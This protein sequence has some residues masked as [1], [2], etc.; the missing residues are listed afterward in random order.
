MLSASR[1]DLHRMGP[2][3]PGFQIYPTK[4][5]FPTSGVEGVQ[6]Q[7]P[8][9]RLRL[10]SP[11]LRSRRGSRF[12]EKN[13]SLDVGFQFSS[14]SSYCN[15]SF[16]GLC[17]PRDPILSRAPF[18]AMASS[19]SLYISQTPL[20]PSPTSPFIAG[21]SSGCF[22]LLQWRGYLQLFGA[23]PRS[24]PRSGITGA[25]ISLSR[26]THTGL[27]GTTGESFHWASPHSSQFEQ[28]SYPSVRHF[29]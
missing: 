28:A 8:P 29:L 12:S 4:A 10:A 24:R 19:P 18:G 16:Y 21:D 15:F 27:M 14:R 2:S 26:Y 17:S 7:R 5:R 13:P 25:L 20:L 1:I 11:F 23:H 22:A 6:L 3:G 9:S